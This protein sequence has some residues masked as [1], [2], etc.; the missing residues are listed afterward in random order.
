MLLLKKDSKINEIF[1]VSNTQQTGYKD[2]EEHIYKNWVKTQEEEYAA[3][4]KAEKEEAKAAELK[5]EDDTE[6]ES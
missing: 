3:L 1:V 4:K 6:T 5:T 2:L